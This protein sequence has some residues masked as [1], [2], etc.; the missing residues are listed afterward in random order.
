MTL[1]HKH[2]FMQ[3]R[4]FLHNLMKSY[5]LYKDVNVELE[6]K[7]EG[8]SQKKRHITFFER[9]QLKRPVDFSSRSG[10][11]LWLKGLL[12]SQFTAPPILDLNPKADF[13]LKLP[14]S[15]PIST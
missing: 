10:F 13:E 3:C 7:C 4:D 14:I 5:N 9:H 8:I 15:F 12:T 2:T 11:D 1:T 6:F